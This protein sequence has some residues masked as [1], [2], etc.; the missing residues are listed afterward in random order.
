MIPIAVIGIDCRFPGA[1]HKDAFWRLMMDGVVTDTKVPTQRWDVD[2]FYQPDG[3]PG[4]MNTRRGH[5]IDKVD[6]FDNDFFGIA[7]IEAAALD[8]QQR[9]LLQSSWRAIEDAGID[10][11]SLAGTPTGVFVGV[12]SSEWSSL[13]LLD[14]AD[15]SPFL[16]TGSGYFMT[17]NRVS[18]HLGLTGPS[19][20]IDSACSSS[21]TAIHQ[22]CAALRS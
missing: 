1:P 4:S 21:L 17:A 5:F 13:Q 14:F 9:L 7:P 19:V 3:L 2:T 15:V 12:M 18:Y 10:P 8:P 20:A 6:A 22:G 16:G 11:R